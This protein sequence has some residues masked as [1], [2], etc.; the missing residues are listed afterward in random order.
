MK[1]ECEERFVTFREEALLLSTA[2]FST[3]IS[4]TYNQ[5]ETVVIDSGSKK[6]CQI[7]PGFELATPRTWSEYVTTVLPNRL[8]DKPEGVCCV[9]WN[10][11]C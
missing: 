10:I 2:T 3:E 11:S 9:F 1:Y 7:L 5:L 6:V 4:V 8:E